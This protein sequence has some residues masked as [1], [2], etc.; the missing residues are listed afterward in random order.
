MKLILQTIALGGLAIV[1]GLSERSGFAQTNPLAADPFG[2]S[3]TDGSVTVR[4][5]RDGAGYTGGIEFKGQTF[6]VTAERQGDQLT[7]SFES[8]G[9]RFAFTAT[10][11]QGALR[12]VTGDTTYTLRAETAQTASAVNPL[13]RPNSSASAPAPDTAAASTGPRYTNAT[14]GYS[15]ALPNGWQPQEDGSGD[16]ALVPPGG[17]FDPTGDPTGQNSEIYL[18][19]PMPDASSPSQQEVRMQIQEAFLAPESIPTASYS[20]NSDGGIV[21]HDWQYRH[22]ETGQPARLQAYVTGSQG[23]VFALLGSGAVNLLAQREADLR[24][25]AASLQLVAG[26]AASG[27]VQSTGTQ[28]QRAAQP[29]AG[30]ASAPD[31]IQR[32]PLAPA[33]PGR[34]SDDNPQSNEWLNHLRGKLL[35]RMSSY[36]SGTAGGYSSNERMV[37]YPNGQ[38]EYYSASSVSVQA[39]GPVYSAGGSSGGQ[40]TRRGTWRI[41]TGQG[42][43]FLALV[44]EGSTKEEYSELDYRDNKTYIDG[45]RV[46]VTV[47]Q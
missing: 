33:T 30:V 1:L 20:T 37:L 41:V 17:S 31:G 21:I 42:T 24:R 34:L 38:F 15:I 45:E 43:S 3:F 46:F 11:E 28:G 18:L 22:P 25:I 13:A 12:F 47:P 36:T 29:T 40:G 5:D 2:G 10:L 26:A 44:Y 8:E 7:G 4:L 27:G 14:A 39:D 32:H 23:S 6:P 19:V 35:S 16:L 9:Q